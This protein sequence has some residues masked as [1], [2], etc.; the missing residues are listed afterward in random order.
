MLLQ[1]P[2]PV[3]S[4]AVRD[5][6]FFV[7]GQLT[8]NAANWT[9]LFP[10]N[11]T[12]LQAIAVR[13]ITHGVDVHDFMT[14]FKGTFKGQTYDHP[15]PPPRI[16]RN[17]KKC[18]DFVPFIAN[19]ILERLRDGSIHLWG[20]VGDVDPPK[21]VLPLTVEPS[22]PRL[23]HDCRYLNLWQKHTKFA[24]ETLTYIPPLA[25][26]ASRFT[27][28]DEKSSYDGHSLTRSSWEFFGIQFGGWYFC[29]TT[30]SFGWSQSAVICQ[31]SC[32]LVT[33]A[34]RNWKISCIQYL[35]DR[36][37][38]EFLDCPPS[39]DTN[40]QRAEIALVTTLALMHHCG[41]TF[42][43]QKCTL[44][45]VTSGVFLGL[46]VDTIRQS[47]AVPASKVEVF[48][49]LRERVIR[50]K[51]IPLRTLQRLQGKACSFILCVPGAKLFCRELNR[52][53]AT[54]KAV[55]M[56]PALLSELIAWRF[57]D[58]FQAWK[59][60][61]SGRHVTL[62]LSTDSSGYSWGAHS[63]DGVFRD[64]WSPQDLPLGIHLK[65]GRAVVL[66]LK[67]LSDSVSGTTV[68]IFCDNQAFLK[69]WDNEGSKDR[70]I[71]SVVKELFD[72]CNELNCDINIKYVPSALN[73]ADKPSRVLSLS[74]CSL[75]PSLWSTLDSRFGPHTWDLMSLDS[76]T[77]IGRD[78][79][80]LTHYTPFPTP[81]SSGVNVLA[82]SLSPSH[83]YY[84]FP[85]FVMVPVIWNFL[86]AHQPP[87]KFTIVAPKLSPLPP[88]WPSL[89][90]SSST[91]FRLASR[92]EVACLKVPTKK[93]PTLSKLPLHYDLFAFR[94]GDLQ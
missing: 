36:W 61:R 65:E 59:P 38:S 20:R 93:G 66:A 15:L 55:T 81:H 53:I 17:S 50:L 94:F 32:L 9:H 46:E 30:M 80:P 84:V 27:C 83:N 40:S 7:A 49:E 28:I 37:V 26:P 89:S 74:D 57:L 24:L 86:S 45:P 34:I 67:S 85:P 78:G 48:A 39:P 3:S 22:K 47:F 6:N 71:T 92:G 8:S 19:T 56:Y 31:Q 87:L 76:N 1:E 62:E 12:P 73:K 82:Q 42:S 14:P 25:P 29:Y 51:T 35:D 79:Q 33:S 2:L 16:F 64:Y 60:W 18:K 72:L 90:T 41:Y 5:P 43:L 52:A 68:D 77:P 11:P 58:T 63:A 54:A 13:A 21:L 88:W 75:S 91:S 4:L 69:A 44:T 70:N 23:I 10:K